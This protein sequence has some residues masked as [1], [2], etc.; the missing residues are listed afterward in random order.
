MDDVR[1]LRSMT[2]LA[3]A[4]RQKVDELFLEAYSVGV[5]TMTDDELDTA[6][7][8]AIRSCRFMPS[9][10]EL[11]AFVGKEPLESLMKPASR[12]RA[13]DRGLDFPESRER[14]FCVECWRYKLEARDARQGGQKQ[15]EG[16]T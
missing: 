7:T 13:C 4:F 14:G 1:Y 3:R 10:V 8:K 11:A 9:P 16:E 2:M 15:I 6:V 12:C 5:D